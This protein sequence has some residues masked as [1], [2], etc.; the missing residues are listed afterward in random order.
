[1]KVCDLNNM[2]AT[3]PSSHVG[4]SDIQFAKL[5]QAIETKTGEIIELKGRLH[6][7]KNELA[8]IKRA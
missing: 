4:N 3:V 1:M 2:Q 8:A 5:L 7:T 6:K